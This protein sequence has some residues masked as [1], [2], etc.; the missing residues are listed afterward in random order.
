M[1]KTLEV[2]D[3]ENDAD[4]NHNSNEEVI[5]AFGY[6]GLR[7]VLKWLGDLA[8]FHVP[9]VPVDENYRGEVVH[10][11]VGTEFSEPRPLDLEET[12]RCC[13]YRAQR[14]NPHNLE[15][16]KNTEY[17]IRQGDRY[18]VFHGTVRIEPMMPFSGYQKGFTTRFM[19]V[20]V[21]PE[22]YGSVTRI[23]ADDI[24]VLVRTEEAG[25]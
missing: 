1:G 18:M 17:L 21:P 23:E 6:P 14:L 16:F 9:P 20:F 11:G 3:N 24:Y 8:G 5:V 2:L 13:V 15:N 19:A 7:G 10:Y 25:E 4:K 12:G 22:M